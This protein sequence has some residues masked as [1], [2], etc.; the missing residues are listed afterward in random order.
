M[1]SEVRMIEYAK[2]FNEMGYSIAF[3]KIFGYLIAFNSRT[4]E[5]ITNDLKLSKGSVS[6]TLRAMMQNGYLDYTLKKG[7]RKKYYKISFSNW[8]SGLEKR[9]SNSQKFTD[10]LQGTLQ[11][12]SNLS[13]EQQQT[14]EKLIG[15]ERLFQKKIKEIISEFDS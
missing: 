1:D 4:F 3:G 7:E 2:F 12:N 6:M 9:I 13:K 11:C 15:F 8:Q 10:L 5:E 14:V